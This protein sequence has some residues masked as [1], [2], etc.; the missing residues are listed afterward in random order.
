MSLGLGMNRSSAEFDKAL[1]KI[2]RASHA[3]GVPA[4]MHAVTS[5]QVR[6]MIELGFD[7]LVLTADIGV[8]RRAFAEDV[9]AAR[10]AIEV[11][12]AP[13]RGERTREQN[14]GRAH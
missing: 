11:G 14:A 2:V 3:A 9:A 8:L 5:V 1:K 12:R 13:P 6:P 4:V 7:E 10:A